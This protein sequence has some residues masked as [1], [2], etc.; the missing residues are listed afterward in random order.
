LFELS[1]LNI[2]IKPSSETVSYD[3]QWYLQKPGKTPEILIYNDATRYSGVPD[4]FS[5]SGSGT[6]FTLT[7]SGVQA[8]DSGVYYCQKSDPDK[9]PKF[10]H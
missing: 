5:G 1:L 4:R 7:I 10:V 9:T 3:L 6:D 8:E 2:H